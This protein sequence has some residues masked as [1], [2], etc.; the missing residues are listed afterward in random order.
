MVIPTRIQRPKVSKLIP[1]QRMTAPRVIDAAD[2]RA[3]GKCPGFWNQARELGGPRRIRK[4]RHSTDDYSKPRASSTTL[5]TGLPLS[6]QSRGLTGSSRSSISRSGSGERNHS[7]TSSGLSCL[8]N[9]ASTSASPGNHPSSFEL[10]QRQSAF[11]HR[12][13]FHTDCARAGAAGY[14]LNRP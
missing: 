12:I 7:A 8:G 13:R 11:P 9:T 14:G 5:S 3:G 10:E 2:T 4:L 1:R 6:S